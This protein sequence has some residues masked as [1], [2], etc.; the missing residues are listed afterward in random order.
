MMTLSQCSWSIES[1][2]F[3]SLFQTLPRTATSHQNQWNN[4]NS[5]LEYEKGI[6]AVSEQFGKQSTI[7]SIT[8]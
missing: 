7:W 4:W 5:N 1:K 2:A 6:R 3:W 8:L